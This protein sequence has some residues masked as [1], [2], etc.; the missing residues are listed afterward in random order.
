MCY[1][2]CP[3]STSEKGEGGGGLTGKA[4]FVF[5]S[6]FLFRFEIKGR[7]KRGGRMRGV[8]EGRSTPP[9]IP[10]LIDFLLFFL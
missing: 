1:I 2:A 8:E 6:T 3:T 10:G 5:Y 4:I 9:P 7:V